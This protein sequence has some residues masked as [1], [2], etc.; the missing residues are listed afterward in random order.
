MDSSNT[1]SLQTLRWTHVAVA[2][3]AGVAFY[4]YL[5][6]DPYTVDK[7]SNDSSVPDIYPDVHD[8]YPGDEDIYPD[9]DDMITDEDLQ[10]KLD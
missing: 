9:D 3:V 8:I 10:T 1:T 5:R 7:N 6:R 4:H 2:I